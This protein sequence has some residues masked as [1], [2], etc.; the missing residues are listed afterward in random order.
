M[1]SI[2]LKI[3]LELSKVAVEG[4]FV[5]SFLDNLTIFLDQLGQTDILLKGKNR[6]S[7]SWNKPQLWVKQ[8][9]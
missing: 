4:F 1:S 9:R 7:A 5:R 2:S 8:C 3:Q 6:E